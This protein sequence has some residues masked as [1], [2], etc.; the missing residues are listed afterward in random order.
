M[1]SPERSEPRRGAG[2]DG[3]AAPYA[4]PLV[5]ALAL[6]AG[7]LTLD[8]GFV[9]DDASALFR[10]PVVTGELPAS[11]A[12]THDYWGGPLDQPIRSYRPLIPFVWHGLWALWPRNPLPFRVLSCLLHV[13]ASAA[14]LALLLRYLSDRRAAVFGALLFAWHPVHSEALGAIVSHSD[15]ASA[16]LG[17]AVLLIGAGTRRR[18]LLGAAGLLVACAAKESAVVFGAA[19]IASEL[20]ARRVKS[21]LPA[22]LVVLGVIAVQLSFQRAP[23][24]AVPESLALSLSGTMRAAYGLYVLGRGSWALVFPTGLAPHHGFAAIEPT[25]RS[26]GLFA[27][28]GVLVVIAAALLAAR[29]LRRGEPVL[30]GALALW[31]GPLALQ[32][33]FIVDPVTDLAERLLY[34][35]SIVAC[36]ALGLLIVRGL[37]IARLQ[38]IALAA[39]VVVFGA[40]TVEAQRAWVSDDALWSR[41]VVVEPRSWVALKNHAA[42]LSMQGRHLEAAW[43][44]LL[45]FALVRSYP[46]PLDWTTVDTL[47]Q[48]P[49]EQRLAMGP[50]VLEPQDGCKFAGVYLANMRKS[51]PELVATLKPIYAAHCGGP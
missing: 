39:V 21:C 26:L 10:N 48:L 15:L 7:A 49:L 22:A 40:L 34:T 12:F 38:T 44:F 42:Q 51:A 36:G 27:G 13:A 16:A 3:K 35:P 8:G 17:C 6:A 25:F 29:A 18:A 1:S 20:L 5:L 28:V 11:A 4:W 9:Y 2:A 19:L 14:V 41:A 30:L 24:G 45:S 33:G 32:S 47:E 31:L 37:P 50:F 46:A 23:G 43:P